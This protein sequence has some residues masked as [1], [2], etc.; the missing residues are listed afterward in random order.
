MGTNRITSNTIGE[1]QVPPTDSHVGTLISA[2]PIPIEPCRSDVIR[3]KAENKECANRHVPSATYFR[4]LS[5]SL[6]RSRA[7]HTPGIYIVK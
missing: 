3:E 2:S 1:T 7:V 5:S 6:R 4:S